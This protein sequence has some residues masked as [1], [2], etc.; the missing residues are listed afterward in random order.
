MGV[1]LS[2]ALR[3]HTATVDKVDQSKYG[4][5]GLDLDAELVARARAGDY[6][7][8]EDLVRQYRNDVFALCYHY[9]RNREDAWDLSQEVFVKAHRALKGFRGDAR[10]KTWLLRIASNRCKDFF[11]K[12]RLRTIALDQEEGT[13]EV[14]S[15]DAGPARQLEAKELGAAIRSA[16]DTLPEKHRTAFVLREFEGLSYEEMSEVM[17]CSPG[18]VMSRLHNARKKLQSA[19]ITMGVVEG[20]KR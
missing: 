10:F 14:L 15:P 9:V 6:A 4:D 5:P 17:G 18:T 8:F 3:Y 2:I 11:K 1:S 13:M 12:R 16:L 20:D 7:A 19:L